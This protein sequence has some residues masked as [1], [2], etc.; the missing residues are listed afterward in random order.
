[1][2][3]AGP[4]FA[5]CTQVGPVP[6]GTWRWVGDAVDNSLVFHPWTFF[7]MHSPSKKM[8]IERSEKG[9]WVVNYIIYV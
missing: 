3:R 2:W 1:M 4:L 8:L 9:G 7:V 6:Q 5:L